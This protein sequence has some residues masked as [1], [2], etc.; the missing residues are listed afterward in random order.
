M[1]SARWP[2]QYKR[3]KR[4]RK[5]LNEQSQNE[6]NRRDDFY[7]FF[8]CGY[9]LADWIRSDDSVADD[10]R[11]SA[12]EFRNTGALGL[13]RDVANGFKHLKRDRRP[14]DA[15]ARVEVIGGMHGGHSE[16]TSSGFVIEGEGAQTWEDAVALADRCIGEWN[17]FLREHGLM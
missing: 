6:E 2:E 7:A 13:A 15:D 14:A 8:V 1:A 9:H 16:P 17:R 12:W 4:W 5:R 10:V 3:M 11:A